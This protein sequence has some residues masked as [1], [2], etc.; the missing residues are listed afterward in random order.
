MVSPDIIKLTSE[1]FMALVEKYEADAVKEYKDLV[2]E[3]RDPYI[4][5]WIPIKEEQC[6]KSLLEELK[7]KYLDLGW[8]MVDIKFVT[9][10]TT[11]LMICLWA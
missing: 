10:R 4:M 6:N 1:E 3:V 9:D 5:Y 2:P 11:S 7:T 8:R